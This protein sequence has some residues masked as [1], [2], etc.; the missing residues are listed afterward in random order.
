MKEDQS[1]SVSQLQ[2]KATDIRQAT[3]LNTLYTLIYI[4][5]LHEAKTLCHASNILNTLLYSFKSC[6]T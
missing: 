4:N 6:Y 5:M 3:T 1:C 2:L